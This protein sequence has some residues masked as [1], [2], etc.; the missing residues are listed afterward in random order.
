MDLASFGI[1]PIAMR[2]DI[3]IFFCAILPGVVARQESSAKAAQCLDI[4]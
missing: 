1:R 3:L 4:I 2:L